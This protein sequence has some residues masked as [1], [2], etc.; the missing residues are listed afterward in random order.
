MSRVKGGREMEFENL[1]LRRFT[2]TVNS[3]GSP[4]FKFY[5]LHHGLLVSRSI[6]PHEWT[7]EDP[8]MT[9]VFSEL[10][11]DNGVVLLMDDDT[12]RVFQTQDLELGGKAEPPELAV[13]VLLSSGMDVSAEAYISWY[14]SIPCENSRSWLLDRFICSEIKLDSW[15]NPDG[16][17]RFVMGMDDLEVI[18]DLSSDQSLNEDGTQI[19]EIDALC[20]VRHESFADGSELTRWLSEWRRH[21]EVMLGVLKSLL[22]V[23]ND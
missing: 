9:P 18:V 23:E 6:I 1:K 20:G 7:I 8:R 21:E 2:I 3:E 11:Y 19:D 16:R 4:G 17:I 12:F 14:I 13:K 15:V 10:A 22:G 5:D